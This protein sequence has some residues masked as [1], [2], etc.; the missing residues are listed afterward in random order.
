M[1]LDDLA[2]LADIVGDIVSLPVKVVQ[3]SAELGNDITETVAQDI[4]NRIEGN[5]EQ[6]ARTSYTVR[7]EAE[8]IVSKSNTRYHEAL[9]GMHR[10]W[11]A[12]LQER[13]KVGEKREE[14]YRMIGKTLSSGALVE[15][16]SGRELEP[17]APTGPTMDSLG[18]NLGTYM[19]LPAAKMRMEIAEEYYQK[20][21]EFRAEM[22]RCV[23]EIH[24]IQYRVKSVQN[25]QEEEM[26]MLQIIQRTYQKR[27]SSVLKESNDLLYQIA[28][29][30]L[31]SVS[32][33]TA[34][35]Y[36]GLVQTLKQLWS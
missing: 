2:I 15:L 36:Q 24:Q 35:R 28:E 10:D 7:D 32:D 3:W 5:P 11:N 16:P 31:Q 14:V 13:Q 25:A 9:G 30:S 12:M 4:Q 26:Q 27:S 22:D 1:F 17:E 33:Q 18:F 20:A 6:E 21:K 8:E 34:K 29:L 19:G 23:G